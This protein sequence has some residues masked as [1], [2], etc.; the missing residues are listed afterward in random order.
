M[1]ATDLLEPGQVV[2]MTIADTG[3]E[4]VGRVETVCRPAN[5]LWI[6]DRKLGGRRLIGMNEI[7]NLDVR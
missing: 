1:H 7:I 5:A 3:E 4:L 2:A 6:V